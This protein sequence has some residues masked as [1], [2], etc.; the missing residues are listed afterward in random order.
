MQINVSRC[1]YK[2]LTEVA[3]TKV[4]SFRKFIPYRRN[5]VCKKCLD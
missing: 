1:F 4:Y 3:E 2:K 5:S